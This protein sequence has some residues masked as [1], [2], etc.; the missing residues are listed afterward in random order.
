MDV[1]KTDHAPTAIGPY[2][3]AVRQGNFI[4]ASGQIPLDPAT[5]KLIE[6]DFDAMV[7]RVFDNLKAVLAS[8]GATFDHV[9]KATVYL[10]DIKDFA[11]L[12]AIYAEYMGSHKPARSTVG[13]AQLPLDAPVEIDLIAMI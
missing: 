6:G 10:K 3:Q 5:G 13:V 9:V 12:N 2:S 7:R 11:K 4:F 1:L 8:G